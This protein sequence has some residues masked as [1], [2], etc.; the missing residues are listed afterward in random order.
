[1]MEAN[2]PISLATAIY[3]YIICL[4]CFPYYIILPN[5]VFRLIVLLISNLVNQYEHVFIALDFKHF[6]KSLRIRVMVNHFCK[7]LRINAKCH[8][9]CICQILLSLWLLNLHFEPQFQP[10]VFPIYLHFLW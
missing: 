8:K 6:C 2:F 3:I 1:M 9:C 4:V 5:S 10:Y 7:F